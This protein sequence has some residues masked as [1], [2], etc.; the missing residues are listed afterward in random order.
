MKLVVAV[1]T[2]AAN[3]CGA[4]DADDPDAASCDAEALHVD[5]CLC[6]KHYD[7]TLDDEACRSPCHWVEDE[8]AAV[9]DVHENVV[10]ADACKQNHHA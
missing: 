4:A 7:R 3:N 10:R 6:C 8:I 2:Y 5:A 1:V 9:A